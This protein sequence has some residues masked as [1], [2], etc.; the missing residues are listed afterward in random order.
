MS[1]NLL[2]SCMV[3]VSFLHQMTPLHVAAARGRVKIVE[4]LVDHEQ[5]PDVNIQ[6]LKGV[7]ICD[8][9]D[10]G[11]RRASVRGCLSHQ[12][13]TG[14]H[15]MLCLFSGIAFCLHDLHMC[16]NFFILKI[17]AANYQIADIFSMNLK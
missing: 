5:G 10:V 13:I 15:S 16:S 17:C 14:S 12:S 3:T 1:E 11:I 8:L 4:Y 9:W 7:N 6:D 2:T